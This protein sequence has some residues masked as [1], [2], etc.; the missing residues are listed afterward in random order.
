MT[1]EIV[2]KRATEHWS[3]S[4]EV[5]SLLR[6]ITIF[7]IFFENLTTRE[8]RVRG[9]IVAT[10]NISQNP[11]V[12]IGFATNHHSMDRSRGCCGRPEET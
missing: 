9:V 7:Q 6:T 4:L 1:M 12:M 8:A 11:R 5:A 10:I 3:E 2:M